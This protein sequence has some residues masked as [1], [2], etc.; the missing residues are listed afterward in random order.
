MAPSYDLSSTGKVDEGEADDAD[1][2]TLVLLLVE[3]TLVLVLVDE[4]L[5]L[6]EVRLEEVAF[7]ELE[8][9]LCWAAGSAPARVEE[10][11][12]SK[13]RRR[14]EEE[15]RELTWSS[16]KPLRTRSS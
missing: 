10:N 16:R 11:R 14:G 8:E 9:D 7:E 6:V 12:K 2:D 1:E 13:E 5:V 3:E 4:P 15:H